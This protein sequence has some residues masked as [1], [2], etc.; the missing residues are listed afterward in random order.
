MKKYFNDNIGFTRIDVD[1]LNR[2]ANRGLAVGHL[3]SYARIDSLPD[4]LGLSMEIDAQVDSLVR[5]LNNF[6]EIKQKSFDAWKIAADMMGYW[7]KGDFDGFS[8]MNGL[9][10]FGGV[11]PRRSFRPQ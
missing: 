7:I 11:E 3:D 9:N 5:F 1:C 2:A 6:D 8:T 4:I 10:F